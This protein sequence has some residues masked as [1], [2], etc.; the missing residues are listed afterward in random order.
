MIAFRVLGCKK[1][2]LEIEL[3]L[4][5]VSQRLSSHNNYKVLK[6]TGQNL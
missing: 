5:D 6:G 4:Q 3:L 1:R 2:R